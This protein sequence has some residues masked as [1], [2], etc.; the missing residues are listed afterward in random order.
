VS[1]VRRVLRAFHRDQ[2]DDLAGEWPIEDL[3]L[4][5]LQQLFGVAPEDPMYGSFP[6]TEAQ[7]GQLAQAAGTAVDLRQYDYF[8]EADAL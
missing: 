4:A 5:D 2:P 7:A 1:E 3:S 6:V 8:I